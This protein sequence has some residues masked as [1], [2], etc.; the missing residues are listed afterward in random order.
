[1]S[2]GRHG[3]TRIRVVGLLSAGLFA[4][5]S[6]D[7]VA[8]T[9]PT[10][11]PYMA[12]RVTSVVPT[13]TGA[14]SMRVEANPFSVNLGL[15]AVA[16]VDAITVIWLPNRKAG[17]LRSL[18]PGQ[19]VRLWFDGAIAQSYPVQGTAATVVID[20]SAISPSGL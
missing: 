12:G 4:C 3:A 7:A 8:P 14:V 11:P 9:E 1:M 19:W 10:S 2:S 5:S 15:K 13:G 16:R 18:T 6:S 20:S 17:D